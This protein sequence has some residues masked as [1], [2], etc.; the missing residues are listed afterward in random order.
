[1]YVNLVRL[2]S[3][4]VFEEAQVLKEYSGSSLWWSFCTSP[5]EAG[6][7]QPLTNV[8]YPLTESTQM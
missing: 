8:L 1:M 2:L 3:I 7:K 6:P 4:T 5:A